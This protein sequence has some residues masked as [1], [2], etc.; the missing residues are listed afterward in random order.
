MF[1]SDTTIV[2]GG[3]M[4]G[5]PGHGRAPSPSDI[6]ANTA[7]RIEDW[8]VRSLD[9]PATF[10]RDTP[11]LNHDCSAVVDTE[12]FLAE[13]AAI[14]PVTA[15][16]RSWLLVSSQG[17]VTVA[18]ILTPAILNRDHIEGLSGAINELIDAGCDQLVIDFATVQRLSSQF[19]A[20]LCQAHARCARAGGLLKLCGLAPELKEALAITRLEK[21]LKS[22]PDTRAALDGPWPRH[23]GI[24]CL[25]VEALRRLMQE[26]RSPAPSRSCA[27]TRGCR[28][29]APS[30]TVSDRDAV[31]SFIEL[32]EAGTHLRCRVILDV[33]VV[34]VLETRLQDE[35]DCDRIR[36][37][38]QILLEQPLPRRVVLDLRH[39]TSMSSMA[40]AVLV[41][42]ALRVTRVGARSV[43][44]TSRH[45]SWGLRSQPG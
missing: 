10:R 40:I 26:C 31:D 34:T 15:S 42:Y 2:V 41:T 39:V 32:P 43:S 30:R 33:L 35:E 21:L 7:R 14:G 36:S 29:M 38:L 4:A 6:E 1:V 28:R 24:H 11:D 44:V 3:T 25:P 5:Q 9:E 37:G 20:V 17:N 16:V 18:L 22:T 12:Q 23:K 19:I 13:Q 8:I 27:P 45:P